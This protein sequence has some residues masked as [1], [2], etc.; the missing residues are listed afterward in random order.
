MQI[1]L[2][3]GENEKIDLLVERNWFT[4]RFTFIANGE[5]HTL[6]SPYSLLTHFNVKTKNEYRFEVGKDEKH[7]VVIQH[8]R[9]RFFAG[10]RNQEFNLIVD[11]ELK[12]SS[13]GY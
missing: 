4:G 9:S 2:T 1:K 13:D 8:I 7:S 12:E 10:F 6:R 3:I 11:G 5:K